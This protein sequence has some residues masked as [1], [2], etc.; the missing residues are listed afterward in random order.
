MSIPRGA[1]EVFGDNRK[2]EQALHEAAVAPHA[3]ELEPDLDMML[4]HLQYLIC[5]N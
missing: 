5:Q 2:V 3:S 4:C 1:F